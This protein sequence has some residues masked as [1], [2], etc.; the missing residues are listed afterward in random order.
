MC[1]NHCHPGR[2][3][4]NKDKHLHLNDKNVERAKNGWLTDDHMLLVDSILKREYPEVDGLQD[5]VQQQNCSR[6]VP[7]SQLYSGVSR[8]TKE[9]IANY[10]NKDKVKINVI[11]VPQQENKSDCGV[12]AITYAQC[13]LEGKN[14][15]EYDFIYSRKHLAQYLPTGCLPKF[16]KD[17]TEHIPVVLHK[18]VHIPMKPVEKS[19]SDYDED[20]LC[21]L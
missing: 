19:L 20:I 7:M 3:C 16:P 2:V 11:N 13:L 12:F 10:M 4:Q 17:L 18:E 9:L 5:T 1:S 8:A 15:A 6:K 14:P 21:L